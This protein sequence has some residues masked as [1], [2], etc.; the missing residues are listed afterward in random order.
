MFREKQPDDSNDFEIVLSAHQLRIIVPALVHGLQPGLPMPN[1]FVATVDRRSICLLIP[2]ISTDQS[3]A[4]FV[5][6][7]F[8]VICLVFDLTND[9]SLENVSDW[10]EDAL[11][12]NQSCNITFPPL[13]FLVGTKKD[14]LPPFTLLSKIQCAKWKADEIKAEL[15]ILSN[16]VN[17]VEGMNA[18]DFFCRLAALTFES[19]M[20]KLMVSDVEPIGSIGTIS[21]VGK[22]HYLQRHEAV[23][24]VE[25]RGYPGPTKGGRTR[26]RCTEEN[27]DKFGLVA[28]T[29]LD[30]IFN[31]ARQ[32][33]NHVQDHNQEAH[34]GHALEVGTTPAVPGG[35]NAIL[36]ELWPMGPLR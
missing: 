9:K 32:G 21:S 16:K 3:I 28:A 17:Y 34:E 25:A 18:V 26:S 5:Q 11:V 20:L 22:E 8:R 2:N 19:Q 10:L 13:I 6:G 27:V 14:L 4:R 31:Q 23:A 33:A 15:W 1:D 35:G 36:G 12:S 30:Y 29:N 7:V 24:L